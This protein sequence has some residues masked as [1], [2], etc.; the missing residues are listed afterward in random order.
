MRELRASRQRDESV[1]VI[2]GEDHSVQNQKVPYKIGGVYYTWSDFESI[3]GSEY[4]G[5]P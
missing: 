4:Y 2:S 5:L 3:M 1:R